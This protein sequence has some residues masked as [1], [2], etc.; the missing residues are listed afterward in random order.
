MKYNNSTK[1]LF[2]LLKSYKTHVF[3]SII[4]AVF[5]VM[6]KT[7][8]SLFIGEFIN[9]IFI[10]QNYSSLNVSHVAI[11]FAFGFLWSG[12]QYIMYLF[13]GKLAI[14]ISH[15]L[16]EQ[17]YYKIIKLPIDFYHKKTSSFILSIVSNDVTLIESFLM[18][19]M[20]QLFAQPLT[21]I[22]I[23]S[24]MFVTN[25]KLSL[26]FLVLGPFI[27]FLLGFVGSY[28]QKL[29]ASMQENVALLTKMFSETMRHISVIKGYNS[30]N[31]ELN[32]FKEK[33]NYQLLLADKEI[34]VR[35]FALPM[36]DFL[37]ITA[38]ILI[39]SLGAI[40]IQMGIATAGDVT[41]FVAMAIVLSEPISSFNQL[42]LVI[43]KLGPS[44]KRVFDIIDTPEEQEFGKPSIGTI[45]G[46][47]TFKDVHF[48]YSKDHPVLQNITLDI[49]AKETIAIIGQ[50]GSGKSTLSALIPKFYSPDKGSILFDGKDISE[51]CSSSIRDNIAIVTQDTSLFSE[52]IYNNIIL[53]KPD[54]TMEEIIIAAKTA[55]A[56]YFIS[57][58]PEG[59]Q[60]FAGDQGN[61]LSG[62]ERQRIILTRAI[63]KNPSI[64]ILDEPTSSLD[65]ESE[66][67]ITDAL[68]NIYGQQTTIII[69]H[70]L[71]TIEKADRIAVMKDGQIVE[72]GSHEELLDQDSYYKKLYTSYSI[73]L[74]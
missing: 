64:L 26:Y 66:K 59:Y 72:I 52:S 17:L 23:I 32:L 44:A 11:L 57:Q 69:A 29:G 3:I 53:S 2:F 5:F 35:L 73:S 14:R 47:I 12:A 28:I 74:S 49:K 70:K 54:A 46:N 36:S 16:R 55:H 48:S 71:S 62:G 50:S 9:D 20:V 68:E 13:S 6:G 34:K 8:V 18:N 25:W 19:V 27:A 38:I 4:A 7:G 43:K 15:K 10:S 30:E 60:R 21:I 51:Y 42:I 40:G 31:T 24:T 61:N 56:D 22:V 65:T 39:L 67:H 58:H 63:L 1:R 45:T 33:N 41:K 37:G